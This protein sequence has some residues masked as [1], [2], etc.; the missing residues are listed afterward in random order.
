MRRHALS[1]W[2]AAVFG[3]SNRIPTRPQPLRTLVTTM[4][5][6]S[7]VLVRVVGTG[8]SCLRFRWDVSRGQ[9]CESPTPDCVSPCGNRVATLNLTATQN[10]GSLPGQNQTSTAMLTRQYRG[11]ISTKRSATQNSRRRHNT[12]KLAQ[13]SVPHWEMRLSA[14][15]QQ[16]IQVRPLA[17]RATDCRRKSFTTARCLRVWPPGW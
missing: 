10:E 16:T 12:R 11:R 9:H 2:R 7:G 5:I 4:A 3:L 6:R 15:M 1:V 13:T 8:I 17:T 14:R